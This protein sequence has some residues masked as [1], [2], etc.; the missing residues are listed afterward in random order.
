MFNS[1]RPMAKVLYELSNQTA[2]PHTSGIAGPS[3]FRPMFAI[4]HDA[5]TARQEC[6]LI[7]DRAPDKVSSGRKSSELRYWMLDS[8][9]T[10][11]PSDRLPRS[12]PETMPPRKRAGSASNAAPAQPKKSKN[13]KSDDLADIEY[14]HLLHASKRWVRVSGSR[15]LDAEYKWL[16]EK[17]GEKAYEYICICHAPWDDEEEEEYGSDEEDEDGEDGGD[18]PEKTK[19]AECDGGKTCLCRKPAAEHPEHELIYNQR[20][21]PQVPR[22]A[23]HD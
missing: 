3:N 12:K 10:I 19:K 13:T 7:Q 21:I 8:P 5:S 22:P 11:Y 1:V 4:S 15:N 18:R 9:I 14:E 2:N 16:R 6:G 17:E 20:R 23:H